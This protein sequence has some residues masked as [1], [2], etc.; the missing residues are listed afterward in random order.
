M[1]KK[2]EK[3]TMDVQGIQITDEGLQF[4]E[5]IQGFWRLAEWEYSTAETAKFITQCFDLGITTFDHADIYGGYRCEE[6]FG[7]AF[8]QTGIPRE[9]IQIVTKCGI[10]LEAPARPNHHVHA[11][12]TT[13]DHILQSVANSLKALQ[14]DYIDVLLIHRPNPLL[15]ADEVADAFMQ[16]LDEKKVFFFGV[17]NFSPS[18]YELLFSRLEVPLVT[19]QLEYSVLNMEHHDTGALDLCQELGIRPMAWSP[20]AGGRL[21]TENSEQANRVRSV[22][23]TIGNELD[24]ASL[25]QVALAFILHHPVGFHPVLGTGKIERVKHAIQSLGVELSNE[26]W[27]RIWEASMGHEVP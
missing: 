10:V 21:F 25:E 3:K 11:Y 4:S 1:K 14:T 26:Q 7:E 24:G 15:N 18:Q 8:A 20:F 13:K 22:L 19:N 27:F 12:D 5:I 23:E 17:S 2:T 9:E 6:L 16:L